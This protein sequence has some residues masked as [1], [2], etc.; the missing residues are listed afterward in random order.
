MSKTCTYASHAEARRAGWF[1]RRHETSEAHQAEQLR[2]QREREAKED[3]EQ[4]QREN[5]ASQRNQELTQAATN[6]AK[7]ALK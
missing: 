3:R 7:E 5:T 6:A 2:T 4:I 1:S